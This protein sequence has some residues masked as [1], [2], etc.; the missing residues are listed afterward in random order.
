[1]RTGGDATKMIQRVKLKVPE[2]KEAHQFEDEHAE[3]FERMG[4]VL[5]DTETMERGG[6]L[7]DGR[8]WQVVPSETER[9][10]ALHEGLDERKTHGN[11]I[12]EHLIEIGD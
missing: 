9:A 4:S 10:N 2:D 6:P 1:M 12:C 8:H 11:F 5:I 7:C 3:L